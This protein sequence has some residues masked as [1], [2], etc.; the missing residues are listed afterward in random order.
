[1]DD[2][3]RAVVVGRASFAYYTTRESS[4]PQ[5]RATPKPKAMIFF[6]ALAPFSDMGEYRKGLLSFSSEEQVCIG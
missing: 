5:K 1:M 2:E 6:T 3:R 4:N